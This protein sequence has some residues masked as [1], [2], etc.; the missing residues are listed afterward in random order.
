MPAGHLA[1]RPHAQP[2]TGDRRGYTTINSCGWESGCLS[3]QLL[4]LHTMR[5]MFHSHIVTEAGLLLCTTG[6][7][8][9]ARLWPLSQKL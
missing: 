4:L 1:K 6:A 5:L 2:I 9:D 7:W 3:Y 8:R